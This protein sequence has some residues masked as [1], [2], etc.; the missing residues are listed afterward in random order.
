MKDEELVKIIQGGNDPENM[1]TVQ[2]WNRCKGF[3]L[4]CVIKPLN[5]TIDTEDLLQE[6]YF[7]FCKALRTY[8]PERGYRFT[9]HLKMHVYA[10]ICEYVRKYGGIVYRPRHVMEKVKAYRELAAEYKRDT[11][12]AP[13]DEI[14]RG[15]FNMSDYN[16]MGKWQLELLKQALNQ[17]E[18]PG[19]LDRPISDDEGEEDQMYNFAQAPNDTE[20]EATDKVYNQER[21]RAVLKA[22]NDLRPQT[23]ETLIMNHFCGLTCSEIAEIKGESRNTVKSR[24]LQGQRQ[25]KQRHGRSLSQF[26]DLS[27][28]YSKGITG[29]GVAIFQQTRTSATERT[30]LYEIEK[31]EERRRE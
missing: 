10:H 1:Y 12:K 20:G 24:L 7:G 18:R 27:P 14:I 5:S 3:I 15:W 13:T 26:I 2:L 4:K 25:M 19:S 23:R 29:T 9:T 28:T 8:E 17:E 21:R 6:S 30:A 22:L 31:E 16:D 11:G